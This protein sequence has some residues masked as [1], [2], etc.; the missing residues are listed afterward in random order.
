LSES[1]KYPR[2]RAAGV[3]IKDGEVL[4]ISHKKNE[5][6]YW[7]L[8]GGGV[9]FGESLHEALRREFLEEL[10]IDVEVKELA[11]VCDSIDPHGERHIINVC[12]HCNY[13]SGEFMLG[14]DERLNGFDFFSNTDLDAL[15]IYPPI[16]NDLAAIID[17][18]S[19]EIYIGKIWLDM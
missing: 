2:V 5:D 7:L 13:V 17:N 19:N 3:L 9:N 12:F 6:V 8:P 15:K 1:L 10:N 16:R 4:L 11:L 18:K 14:D